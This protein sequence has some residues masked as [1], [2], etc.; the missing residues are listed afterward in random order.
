MLGT[1]SFEPLFRRYF[2]F[3]VGPLVFLEI[4]N[5]SNSRLPP[6]SL[7]ASSAAAQSGAARR[8]GGLQATSSCSN[9]PR[10]TPATLWSHSQ[11]RWTSPPLAMLPRRAP[12]PPPRRRRGKLG[13]EPRVPISRALQHL[14]TPRNPI[15]SLT[16]HFP[17]PNHQ[18]TA[19]AHPHAGELELT[20]APL[21]HGRSTRADPIPSSTS[22]SCSSPATP[23]PP[24]TAGPTSPPTTYAE[25]PPSTP[26][27]TFPTTPASIS[28][29]K[30]CASTSSS[31]SP[32]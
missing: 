28:G 17:A 29:T 5:K 18:N 16:H 24:P 22:L 26:A 9:A 30:R 23:L 3:T 15:P 11:P 25:P 12:R 21:L 6:P 27:T 10:G 1:F 32:T 31:Y 7:P 19:T 4:I 20:V 14:G 13:E 8:R 2:C